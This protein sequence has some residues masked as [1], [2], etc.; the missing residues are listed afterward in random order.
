M[1][2]LI[3]TQYFPPEMGAPQN[4]LFELGRFFNE[5]SCEVIVLTSMPNYPSGKLFPGYKKMFSKEKTTNSKIYRSF[6]FPT[7]N[8][9]IFPRLLSYF[10]FAFS[11]FIFGLFIPRPDVIITESPPIFLGV[12]GFLLGKIKRSKWILNVSDLWPLSVYELGIVKKDSFA[13]RISERL[14][15]FLYLRAWMITGQS[16]GITAY[17]SNISGHECYYLPNG[18]DFSRFYQP[19]I[20]STNE[21]IKIVYAGLHG[22]AQGLDQILLA[23]DSFK[24]QPNLE[25]LFYGDGPLKRQLVKQAKDKRLSN[26]SFFDAVSSNNLPALLN[27]A[28]IVLVPLKIQL[29]GAVPSKLFEA[30]A[31]GKPI[32]LIGESEASEIV[33]SSDCGICVKPGDI[34]GLIGAIRFLADSPTE[35]ERL[36]KNGR[37][38]AEK[39][40]DRSI[41]YKKFLNFLSAGLKTA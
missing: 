14:E 15:K 28:Q 6:I 41:T 31:S 4:R 24:N 33:K 21:K 38:A 5:N 12:A 7:N 20:N 8:P 39:K 3:H 25:F 9:G 30:M 2:I 29:T 35:R 22:L 16:K 19:V 1:R 34:S 26:C 40:Y 17:I 32:I 27:Q 10:S 37:I 23:A 11:S 13:Y 36:G 18:V